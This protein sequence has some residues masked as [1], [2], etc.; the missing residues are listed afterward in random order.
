MVLAG[1]IGPGVPHIMVVA[2]PRYNPLGSG[3]GWVLRGF[4]SRGGQY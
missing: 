4:M 1:G 3:G 2:A